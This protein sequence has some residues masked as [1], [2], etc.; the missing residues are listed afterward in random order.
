MVTV[1]LPFVCPPVF[2]VSNPEQ[3]VLKISAGDAPPT[4]N[5]GLVP[6][7]AILPLPSVAV[8]AMLSALNS[9]VAKPDA[10]P[11]VKVALVVY[12]GA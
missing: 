7:T 4:A 9:V 11:E 2:F 5:G 1:V 3:L 10:T 6:L 8:T 12:V